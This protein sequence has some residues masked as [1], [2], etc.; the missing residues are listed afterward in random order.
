MDKPEFVEAGGR[1]ITD[2]TTNTVKTVMRYVDADGCVTERI[3]HCTTFAIFKQW[4]SSMRDAE[5]AIDAH[6]AREN[7][8]SMSDY[9]RHADTA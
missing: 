4:A 7:V 5:A 2:F 6:L 3:T 1:Y 8:T 9:K